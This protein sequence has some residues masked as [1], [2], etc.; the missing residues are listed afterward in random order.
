MLSMLPVLGAQAFELASSSSLNNASAPLLNCRG[1]GLEAKGFESTQGFVVKAGSQAMLEVVP[2][3][4]EHAR[5]AYDK[6]Q[7]V[8]ENGVLKPSASCYVFDQD[9]S[10]TSPSMAAAIVLGRSA[11]GRVEWKDTQGRTLK[12]LQ[13]QQAEV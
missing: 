12:E 5:V 2:S 1:K 9:Y 6:R 4:Q 3:M 13:M 7:E 10:F 8:I 11:N